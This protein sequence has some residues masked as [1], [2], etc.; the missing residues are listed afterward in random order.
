MIRIAIVGVVGYGRNL[1]KAIR[2]AGEQVDCRLVAAADARLAECPEKFPEQA[3]LLKKDGV[4]LYADAIEMY[5]SMAGRCEVIYVATGINAHEPLAVEALNRGYHV[6]VEKPPAATVQAVDRM[7][8]AARVARRFCIVGFQAIHTEDIRF[9]KSR[10]V[11][12]RLG[13]IDAIT[14]QAGWPRTRA[15]YRRNEWAGKLTS[16][17]QW[18]LDGPAMNAMIH[19]INNML[20][21]ASDEPGRFATPSAVR[22]EMYAAGPIESHDTAAIEIRTASGPTCTILCT[23]CNDSRFG[24]VIEITGRKGHAVWEMGAGTIR[25]D[26]GTSESCPA[27]PTHGR[28]RI[29]V[30]FLN[31][32]RAGD[33][34]LLGCDLAASRNTV[35][36]ING[37]FESSRRIHRIDERFSRR[38]DEG[39][40]DARTVVV[41]LDELIASAAHQKKLF[42]DLDERPDWAAATEPFD[43]AGY[44][45]FPVQFSLPPADEGTA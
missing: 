28:H 34:S 12:G 7:L 18:V 40:D 22:A 36:A 45:K 27:D 17:G 13:K 2:Q 31:A 4:E 43:L 38:I 37:A 1:V 42:S 3:D 39:T 35:L 41:G 15:Y 33:A 32:I 20:F 25:Y 11:E 21:F 8:E 16:A 23:H 14:C 19:Q 6:H 5:E 26:D 10:I 9:V 44:R 29:V 30:D 24:P